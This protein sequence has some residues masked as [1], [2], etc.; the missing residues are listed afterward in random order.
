MW[1]AKAMHYLKFTML[2]PWHAFVPNRKYGNMATSCWEMLLFHQLITRLFQPPRLSVMW[3]APNGPACSP[4]CRSHP[5]STMLRRSPQIGGPHLQATMHYCKHAINAAATAAMRRWDMQPQPRP[6][7]E[8][9]A[10]G[11]DVGPLTASAGDERGDAATSA[12]R[13]WCQ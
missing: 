7:H 13:T 2:S 6:R 8:R 9:D 5:L 4:S 3:L 11:Q 1:I 10:A 12:A